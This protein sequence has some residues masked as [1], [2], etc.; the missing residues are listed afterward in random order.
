M[1]APKSR[2]W[3][4]LITLTVL[5]G[6]AFMLNEV[7]LAALSPSVLVAAR[8]LIAVIVLFGM[9]VASGGSLPRSPRAWLS[10]AIMAVL[11]TIVPFHLTA[12]GQQHLDSG[13]TAVLMAIMPL[14]V[15]TLSRFLLPDQR[16]TPM[17]AIGLV[18]GLAGVV[19]VAGPS[20]L[21]GAMTAAKLFGVMAVLGAAFSYSL[22]SVYARRVSTANPMTLAAGVLLVGGALSVPAAI[23]DLPA[24]VASID[25]RSIGAVLFLGLLCTGLASVLYF[26]LIQGP[27]PAFV[28]LVNYLIPAWAVVAGA[29][30]LNERIT[31]ELTSGL[32]LILAGIAIS[33]FGGKLIDRLRPTAPVALQPV[34]VRSDR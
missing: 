10:I 22:N 20:G 11:G 31:A 4:S 32:A 16:I 18:F 19:V 13:M 1:P 17:K 29:L 33:E 6:S 15:L 8:I 2:D 5:W 3:I 27:G 9:L 34:R 28:S 21:G 7:A 24:A 23:P 12:L 25:A 14:F 26:R 30:F